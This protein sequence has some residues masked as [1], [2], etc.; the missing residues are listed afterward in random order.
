MIWFLD[1]IVGPMDVVE[2]YAQEWLGWGI[3]IVVVISA[4]VFA[5]LQR[6]K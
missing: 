2:Y 1:A 4:V 3:G 5:L 6:K